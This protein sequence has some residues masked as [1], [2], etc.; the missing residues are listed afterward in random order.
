M[1]RVV[2]GI[3]KGATNLGKTLK[4]G[5]A[6]LVRDG[7]LLGAIAEERLAREKYKGGSTLAA[8]SLLENFG[9]SFADV[10]LVVTSTCCET[11]CIDNNLSGLFPK[12]KL[13]SCNHHLSHA[14]GAY[15]PSG[16]DDAI[17]MVLDGGGNVLEKNTNDDWWTVHREQQTY[18]RATGNTIVPIGSDF[19]AP[20]DVGLGELYRAFT[21]FLGWEGSRK[22]GKLMSLA[23]Y[24]DSSSFPTG[25]LVWVDDSGAMLSAVKCDPN[26][27]VNM[28]ALAINNLGLTAKPRQSNAPI[29]QIHCDIASWVQREVES[30]LLAK[31]KFLRDTTGCGKFCIAGGVAY[32]CRAIGVLRA[33][34]MV[35]DIYVGPGA[36]DQGQCVGN[37]LYGAV[38][39]GDSPSVPPYSPYLGLNHS[40]G[41]RDIIEEAARVSP[42]LVVT[43]P[44]NIESTVADKLTSGAIGAIMQGRSEFGLRA[45]GNRS[46]VAL[47]QNKRI[48][49]L[50]NTIKGRE[51]F[52]PFAPVVT[53]EASGDYFELSGEFPYMTSALKTKPLFRT[54]APA[55]VH[56]DNSAR[57]QTVREDYCPHLYRLLNEIKTLTGHPVLMNTSFNQAGAPIVENLVDAVT[58][59]EC[60]EL[61]FLWIENALIE[62]RRLVLP[63]WG[64]TKL[65]SLEIGGDTFRE[66]DVS[67]AHALIQRHA[68][69]FHA[70]FRNLFMLFQPYVELFLAGKKVTTVRYRKGGLDLPSRCLLPL[71]AS[72]DFSKAAS[73]RYVGKTHVDAIKILPFGALTDNDGQRDGFND[74]QE[75]RNALRDIYGDVSDDDLV[76]V[77]SIS[78]A[79]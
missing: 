76:T 33:S 54:I 74:L 16:F 51:F 20:L 14:Y 52:M 18:F 55:T 13:K 46:I 71:Y 72:G 31:V 41:V 58:A 2:L 23:A 25:K 6:A 40:F 68:G 45:L 44:D 12:A 50:V 38:L 34:G 1:S 11:E 63:E 75:L 26:N 78:A 17:I 66:I 29:E 9:L 8:P 32:N 65:Q 21:Y 28:A 4:D 3:N 62:R 70:E 37:A 39:L 53:S 15:I 36:G 19:S 77:Y 7:V 42:D 56:Y 69:T 22:A 48:Q 35:D 57:V 10:D 30:A 73:T 5:G 27:A 61:D 60:M 43:T 79:D 67:D 59:F 47:P 49:W 64:V 24:G